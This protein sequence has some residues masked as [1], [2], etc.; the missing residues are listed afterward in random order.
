MIR[1][2]T[3][4]VTLSI[5][6]LAALAMA[7]FLVVFL[8]GIMYTQRS[9]DEIGPNK[10][11]LYV[12]TGREGLLYR[13]I[14]ELK[15]KNEEL[16]KRVKVLEGLVQ[17]Q[18]TKG[19]KENNEQYESRTK[20]GNLRS[21]Q[22]K[23]QD[24]NM[25]LD[26]L[27]DTLNKADSQGL[28][29]PPPN[30][31][32][33]VGDSKIGKRS[34]SSLLGES[35]VLLIIASNRPEY[36][37][38]TLS[39]V[40]KYHPLDS[41]PIVVSEDGNSP[42]VAEVIEEMKSQF[43]GRNPSVP[44]LHIHNDA[45]NQYFEDGYWKL[46]AHFKWALNQVFGNKLIKSESNNENNNNYID[47]HRVILLE[48]D[49]QIA[50]DFFEYF[51]STADLLDTDKRLMAVSAWNDNGQGVRVQDNKALYRFVADWI[52]FDIHLSIHVCMYVCMYVCM[53]VN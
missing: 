36:L 50:P 39:Y 6:R 30:F 20:G 28:Q 38:K 5:T 8:A 4:P 31:V 24:E 52:F 23:L 35:T 53:C 34:I 9:A 22:E 1:R 44:F 33:H 29:L 12:S 3:G 46:C 16:L 49:L 18:D 42:R 40:I 43:K 21:N 41:V 32:S 19:S 2:P 26:H 51:A 37:K 25:K 47:I 10:S 14:T 11:F 7:F 27:L 17:D 45:S 48:E 15:G 13:N